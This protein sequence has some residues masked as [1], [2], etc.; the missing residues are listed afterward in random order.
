MQ[1][2]GDPDLQPALIAVGEVPRGLTGHRRQTDGFQY[3]LD[4][5]GKDFLARGDHIEG[6]LPLADARDLDVL[7]CRQRWKELTDLEALADPHAHD[8]VGRGPGDLLVPE[9]HVTGA[10]R[11]AIRDEVQQG[12]LARPVGADDRADLP[13]GQIE[14]DIVHR[15]QRSEIP[16]Q[17]VRSQ[18]HLESPGG[19]AFPLPR[20]ERAASFLFPSIPPRKASTHPMMIT[21]RMPCHRYV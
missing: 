4:L 20:A 7:E 13:V 16:G 8:R 11:R 9:V 5:V 1:P 17:T 18:D 19:S 3:P 15:A 2:E 21:P 6:L 10:G 14:T 12:R